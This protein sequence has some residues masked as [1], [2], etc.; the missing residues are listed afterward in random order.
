MAALP[1][2][3]THDFT[4]PENVIVPIR[5]DRLPANVVV[6]FTEGVLALPEVQ[7]AIR[8]GILQPVPAEPPSSTPP[9]LPCLQTDEEL[10]IEHGIRPHPTEPS[11]PELPTAEEIIEALQ[12]HQELFKQV[13]KHMVRQWGLERLG[14]IPLDHE[15]QEPP[16]RRGVS[17]N[18][19]AQAAAADA[20]QSLTPQQVR[21]RISANGSPHTDGLLKGL[22]E[23]DGT[24]RLMDD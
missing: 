9:F 12:E 11:E 5:D 21:A 23:G 17:S 7:D 13:Q 22:F 15:L 2:R 16:S 6:L 1:Y 20:M 14:R 24:V 8:R 10:E 3:A 19:Q 4:F 18:F